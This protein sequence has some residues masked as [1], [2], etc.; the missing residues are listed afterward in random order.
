MFNRFTRVAPTPERMEYLFSYGTL[1]QGT[2]QLRLFGR[3]LQSSSDVLV[4]YKLMDV[5]VKDESFLSKGEKSHQLTVVL[6]GK[7]DDL[8]DGRV[9]AMTKEELTITDQYE[10]KE[11]KRM[12][13]QLE[14]GKNAW[15]YLL[16]SL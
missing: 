3:I 6:S 16:M 2:V 5:E 8:V 4:G 9:L 1:Q 12:R 15:I 14:S 10:P 11:Y 13:V 7:K